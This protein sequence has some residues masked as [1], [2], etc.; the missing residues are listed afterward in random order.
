VDGH[1]DLQGV[2]GHN[3]I[4]PLQRP[5]ELKGRDRLTPQEVEAV[6]H[7][8]AELFAGDG[9][10]AFSDSLFTAALGEAKEFKSNDGGTG[11][12]NHFWV[13][14]RTVDKRTSLIVDPPDGR[15]PPLTPEAAARQQRATERRKAHPADGPEDRGL[16]ERCITYGLPNVLAGYNSNVQIVQSRE[17][18]VVVHEMI[19]DARVIPIDGR[20]HLP[21]SVRQLFGDSRARW[22]GDTLVIETTN[23]APNA[24]RESSE[25]LRLTR[26]GKDEL[27][28]EFTIDD[29]G[30]WTK[31][32]SALLPWKRVDGMIY[33]YAC[34]EGSRGLYGILAGHR[35][36][37]R[38]AAAAESRAGRE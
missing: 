11:N 6:K 5:V 34:H 35:E 38:K 22:D 12:Y 20:P 17:C 23:F 21:S 14:E 4:T 29:P 16:S 13:A 36:D 37:E 31:P 9:D 25:Q 26:V 19:H 2:W 1:P 24:F 33:E 7:R 15:M 28:Y 10:A 32:W 27:G 3:V 8:A 30:T 18:V